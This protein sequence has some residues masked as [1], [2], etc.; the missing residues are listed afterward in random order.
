MLTRRPKNWELQQI[1]RGP[2]PVAGSGPLDQ[3]DRLDLA[4]VGLQQT[5]EQR[6]LAG[7]GAAHQ[8]HVA[9]CRP[10]VLQLGDELLDAPASLGRYEPHV[11][12]F[13]RRAAHAM[14]HA[15]LE[16]LSYVIEVVRVVF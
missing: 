12:D 16:R 14:S 10:H 9:A 7:I 2:G 5:V 6:R 4:I 11:Q 1:E 8:V 15:P 3:V 13:R